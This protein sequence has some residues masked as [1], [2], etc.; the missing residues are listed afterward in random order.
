[1]NKIGNI[2]N[3]F[4]DNNQPVRPTWAVM[5]MIMVSPFGQLGL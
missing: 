5:M 3:A 2:A 1:M 4:D